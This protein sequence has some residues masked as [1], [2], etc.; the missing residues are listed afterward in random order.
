MC[1]LFLV[2]RGAYV[3]ADPK[4]VSHVN[5][6]AAILPTAAEDSKVYHSINP[7][8]NPHYMACSLQGHPQNMFGL[9]MANPI[10]QA[11]T[12]VPEENLFI[13]PALHLEKGWLPNSIE[14]SVFS[15]HR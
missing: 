6:L 3:E 15:T 13:T 12:M 4:L 5:G 11:D 8:I 1:C 9:L 14:Q 2:V 7:T 10:T